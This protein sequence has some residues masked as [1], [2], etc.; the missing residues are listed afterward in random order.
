MRA[1]PV[2][3][4]ACLL[5]QRERAAGGRER[6]R[7]RVRHHLDIRGQRVRGDE[8]QVE[9][10]ALVKLRKVLLMLKVQAAQRVHDRAHAWVHLRAAA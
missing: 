1:P 8:G 2:K 3:R 7:G 4:G 10:R 9:Q 6:A 5:R